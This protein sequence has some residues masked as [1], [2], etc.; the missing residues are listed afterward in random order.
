[1]H[2]YASRRK[3]NAMFIYMYETKGLVTFLIAL[4]KLGFAIIIIHVAGDKPLQ[5]ST[6][7]AHM[8][9]SNYGLTGN[10]AVL[11]LR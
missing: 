11:I 8:G 4:Y 2:K 10:V 9:K 6:F 1:M 3:P 5:N 7:D